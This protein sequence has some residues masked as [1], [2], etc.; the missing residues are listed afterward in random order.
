LGEHGGYKRVHTH[1]VL[2]GEV[3]D[4]LMDGI[5]KLN[6]HGGGRMLSDYHSRVSGKVIW[7]PRVA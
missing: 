3:F 1:P 4:A 7:P 5:R 2:A 6:G